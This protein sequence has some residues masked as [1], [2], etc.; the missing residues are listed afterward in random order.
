M[1]TEHISPDGLWRWDGAQWVAN[2]QLPPTQPVARRKGMS[3]DKKVIGGVV[4]GVALLVALGAAMSGGG[5]S[6]SGGSGS[7]GPAPVVVYHVTGSAT[8]VDITAEM[9]TGTTQEDARSLPLRPSSGVGEGIEVN[10]FRSGDFV[11]LSAQRRLDLGGGP[12][13]TCKIT[14]DGVTISANTA[15]GGASIAS[16]QGTVP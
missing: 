8:A 10:G 2:R 3:E 13:V 1:T 4:A 6:G 15:S 12:D 7:S 14:V 5:G 11:Y 16:C 9:P